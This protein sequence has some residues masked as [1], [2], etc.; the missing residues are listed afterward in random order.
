[1]KVKYQFISKPDDNTL[2]ILKNRM[3]PNDRKAM[4]NGEFGE[5]GAALLIEGTIPDMVK[6]S[7]VAVKASDV[8]ATE[9]VGNCPQSFVTIGITGKIRSVQTALKAIL[10]EDPKENAFLGD[11]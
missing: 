6:A 8:R 5:I 10:S 11:V 2:A 3:R 1:M 7:D 9:I 4:D